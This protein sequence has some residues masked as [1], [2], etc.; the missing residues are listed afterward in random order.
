MPEQTY[1]EAPVSTRSGLPGLKYVNTG[2][3]HSF[4]RSSSNAACYLSHL[5]HLTSFLVRSYRG[6]AVLLNPSINLRFK[7][8]NLINS[9]IPFL[10]VGGFQ[11]HIAAVLIRSTLTPSLLMMNPRYSVS[12]L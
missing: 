9:W 11:S 5:S 4:C 10:L 8:Q 3:E 7:L 1:F 12:L 2:V 6:L